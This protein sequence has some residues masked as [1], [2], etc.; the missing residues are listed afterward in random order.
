M[1]CVSV[2]AL[3]PLYRQIKG[4]NSTNEAS[5]YNNLTPQY[6]KHSIVRSANRNEFG[7][8]TLTETTIQGKTFGSK[9]DQRNDSGSEE[10]IIHQTTEVMLSYEDNDESR[11][12]ERGGADHSPVQSRQHL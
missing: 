2:P 5:D 7:L 1:I 10:H 3:R 11:A 12:S 6:N 8:D 4:S 9:L